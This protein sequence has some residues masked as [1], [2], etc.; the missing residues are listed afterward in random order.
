M[1]WLLS[2]ILII[3]SSNPCPWEPQCAYPVIAH[4]WKKT[5]DNL[6]IRNI[7]NGFFLPFYFAATKSLLSR[8]GIVYR[9]LGQLFFLRNSWRF[10]NEI[11]AKIVVQLFEVGAN[12]SSVCKTVSSA[13][14]WIS[15]CQPHSYRNNHMLAKRQGFVIIQMGHPT[16]FSANNGL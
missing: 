12:F 11:F 8:T 3:L 6:R 14:S 10:I 1:I 4:I 9:A 13:A 7:D 15:I 5:R 16:W 2:V